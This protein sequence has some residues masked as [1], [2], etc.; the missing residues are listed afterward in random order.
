MESGSDASEILGAVLKSLQLRHL[1]NRTIGKTVNGGPI[2]STTAVSIILTIHDCIIL[3]KAGIPTLHSALPIFRAELDKLHS[4]SEPSQVSAFVFTELF[5]LGCP[6]LTG[7]SMPRRALLPTLV[8][9]LVFSGLLAYALDV[10]CVA[11]VDRNSKSAGRSPS[12]LVPAHHPKIASADVAVAAGIHT[13]MNNLPNW[14][15]SWSNGA[16]SR[17]T[18][19]YS[20]DVMNDQAT[21]PDAV[22]IAARATA[23]SIAA[24]HQ[25]GASLITSYSRA[26]AVDA[27]AQAAGMPC[28]SSLMAFAAV[29]GVA[30]PA[31]V[32]A[33]AS[34]AEDMIISGT[35]AGGSA[36]ANGSDTAPPTARAC[37]AR[38]ALATVGCPTAPPERPLDATT[39]DELLGGVGDGVFLKMTGSSPAPSATTPPPPLTQKAFPTPALRIAPALG[40]VLPPRPTAVTPPAGIFSTG[41]SAACAVSDS[42][43]SFGKRR[44]NPAEMAARA[45]RGTPATVVVRRGNRGGT[46]GIPVGGA[47]AG[48]DGVACA[49]AAAQV[50]TAGWGSRKIITANA[51]SIAGATNPDSSRADQRGAEVD[52]SSEVAHTITSHNSSSLD[53]ASSPLT[54]AARGNLVPHRAEKNANGLPEGDHIY[55]DLLL[56]V[57]AT[58]KRALTAVTQAAVLL[59]DVAAAAFQT[60]RSLEGAELASGYVTPCDRFCALVDEL[61][62]AILLASREP[63]TPDSDRESE[64]YAKAVAVAALAKL[65]S[66]GECAASEAF[67]DNPTDSRSENDGNVIAPCGRQDGTGCVSPAFAAL[68]Q[69][70]SI[71]SDQPPVVVPSGL[72]GPVLA[73]QHAVLAI[74]SEA[75]RAAAALRATVVATMPGADDRLR[76]AGLEAKPIKSGDTAVSGYAK[77][78]GDDEENDATVSEASFEDDDDAAGR[79]SL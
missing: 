48:R 10:S 67:G 38:L 3:W 8:W 74:S 35:T 62:R 75:E 18:P 57:C 49:A 28:G 61:N 53:K 17:P 19:T 9:F 14:D 31:I 78:A 2:S 70:R 54:Q 58:S 4:V 5:S 39:R 69:A 22:L 66:L 1:S 32:A 7:P 13:L 30:D 60:Q 64:A 27:A 40:G 65:A 20:T 25:A 45:P 71:T 55:E 72:Q 46:L 73:L 47:S 63:S 36:C 44:S 76:V 33:S 26:A 79:I 42:G 59:A 15:D 51:G 37:L 77:G 6:L 29:R 68:H 43:R 24:V 50:A 11:L 34:A 23:A 12:L 56:S 16:S 52:N 41:A 21:R